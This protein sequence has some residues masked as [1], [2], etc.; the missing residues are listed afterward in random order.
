MLNF[1]TGGGI[2]GDIPSG[3]WTINYD[4]SELGRFEL[5]S[6][7]PVDAIL[8]SKVFMPSVKFIKEGDNF[9]GGEIEFYMWN[10]SQYV[11]LTDLSPVQKLVGENGLSIWGQ[12]ADEKRASMVI[13]AG[14]AV[15]TA[16]FEEPVPATGYSAGAF[17]YNIGDQSYRVEFHQH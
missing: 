12:S 14:S 17:Y 5:A 10:G 4:G 9:V 7:K 1:G 13:T 6:A 2:R 11:K 15:A 3:L 8:K 16:T